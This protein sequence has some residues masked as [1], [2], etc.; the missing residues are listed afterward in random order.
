M[1]DTPIY[2]AVE[3]EWLAWGREVPRAPATWSARGPVIT[4]DLFLR[5]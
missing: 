4:G 3:R 2:D 5:A 1:T